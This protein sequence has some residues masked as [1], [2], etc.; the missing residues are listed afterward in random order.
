MTPPLPQVLT[1]TVE[2]ETSSMI[3]FGHIDPLKA[4]TKAVVCVASAPTLSPLRVGDEVLSINSHDVGGHPKLA[5]S[6]LETGNAATVVVLRKDIEYREAVLEAELGAEYNIHWKTNER[7][8]I[9]PRKQP[10]K[11]QATVFP[12]FKTRYNYEITFHQATGEITYEDMYAI[13]FNRCNGATPEQQ[14]RIQESRRSVGKR[15]TLVKSRIRQDREVAVKHWREAQ[16]I[17]QRDI[18]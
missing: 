5:R 18:V 16:L 15:L 17:L 8:V 3:E 10:S 12:M 2:A 6:L 1:I 4:S 11:L 7:A 9:E 13:T 14:E